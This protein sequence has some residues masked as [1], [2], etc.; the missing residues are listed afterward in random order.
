[1]NVLFDTQNEITINILSISLHKYL[2]LS[3]KKIKF[4]IKF[5]VTYTQKQIEKH[6]IEKIIDVAIKYNEY[7]I[8]RNM[9]RNIIRNFIMTNVSNVFT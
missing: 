5:F 6:E 7:I 2:L 9:T 8:S 3:Q 1:M 4:D